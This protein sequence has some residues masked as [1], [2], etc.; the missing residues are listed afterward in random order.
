MAIQK[1]ELRS[2]AEL[3][4][5]RIREAFEQALRRCELDCMDRPATDNVRKVSLTAELVP[6]CSPGGELESVDVR[7]HIKDTVPS[8]KSA[9]YNMKA[10]RGGLLFNEL[11]PDD[12]HQRTIDEA[13]SPRL[14]SDAS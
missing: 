10:T 14:A 11:S 13:I 12:I 3:D 6:V 4:G 2:L 7:F 1:F 5:G 8:R 9:V